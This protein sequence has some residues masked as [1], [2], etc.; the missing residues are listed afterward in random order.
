MLKGRWSTVL[1][2]H[3]VGCDVNN[4]VL[5]GFLSKDKPINVAF[6]SDYHRTVN[7]VLIPSFDPD[8][9]D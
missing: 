4:L 1:E 3:K 6:A 5:F 2:T 9:Y 8:M 7:L